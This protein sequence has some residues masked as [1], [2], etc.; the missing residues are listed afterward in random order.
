MTTLSHELSPKHCHKILFLIF[1]LGITVFH[2]A[3]IPPDDFVA[4]CT[5]PFE[6]LTHRE[7]DATDFWVSITLIIKKKNV[8]N[9]TWYNND[10]VLFVNIVGFKMCES[11][12]EHINNEKRYDSNVTQITAASCF[13]PVTQ[14]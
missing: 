12:K 9:N 8:K 6:D 3:A 13:R 11:S 2:D 14:L 1:S 4:N 10:N 5:I 7:K